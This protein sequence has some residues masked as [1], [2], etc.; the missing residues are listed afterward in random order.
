VA[1]P[2]DRL[3]LIARGSWSDVA[4]LALDESELGA[5]LSAVADLTARLG[6]R[7]SALYRAVLDTGDGGALPSGLNAYASVF[8]TF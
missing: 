2:W 6:L 4:A 3:R 7:L 1:R 5:S 8:A